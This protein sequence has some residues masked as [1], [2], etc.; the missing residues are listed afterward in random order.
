[1]LLLIS[2]KK[3]TPKC[4]LTKIVFTIRFSQNFMQIW[5]KLCSMSRPI[6]GFCALL[7]PYVEYVYT[8]HNTDLLQF[9][10]SGLKCYFTADFMLPSKTKKKKINS[11][12]SK[13]KL[14]SIVELIIVMDKLYN[15]NRCK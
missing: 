10:A 13:F 6:K 12:C 8:L 14:V 9:S 7:N 4:I 3:F 1:M 2:I 15:K 5:F 11:T